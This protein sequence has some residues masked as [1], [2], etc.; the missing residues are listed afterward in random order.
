MADTKISGLASGSPAVGTDVF[1]I[2]R[3]GANYKLTLAQMLAAGDSPI[4][5]TTVTATA[6]G[7]SFNTASFTKA[8][9]G[10]S[11][12]WTNA[13]ASNKTGYLYSDAA[14]AGVFYGANG[15][16]AGLY[17]SA[18]ASNL[19]SPSQAVALAVNNT[20]VAITGALA[21]TGTLGSSLAG[22]AAVYTNATTTTGANTG[23]LTNCPHTGNPTLYW[24]VSINGTVYAI[25]C[26]ALS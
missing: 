24:E 3:G 26:F 11:V 20:N 14:S 22:V 12:S 8:T 19:F 15:S 1:P 9:A 18:T 13:A 7:S 25:P 5:G 21:A 6:A 2:A 17:L 23:T 4:T 10:D 16:G